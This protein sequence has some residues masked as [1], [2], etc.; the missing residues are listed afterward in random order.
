[1]CFSYLSCNFFGCRGALKRFS[2]FQVIVGYVNIVYFC[3]VM[4]GHKKE[5]IE[6]YTV[7]M[8]TR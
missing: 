4:T 3:I 2:M 6:F 8:K 7:E 1:M 5:S